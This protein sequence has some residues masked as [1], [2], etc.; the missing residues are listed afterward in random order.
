MQWIEESR[1]EI[2]K[3]EKRSF[4]SRAYRT[5]RSVCVQWTS[6][7]GSFPLPLFSFHML[8]A[9]SFNFSDS[10]SIHMVLPIKKRKTSFVPSLLSLAKEPKKLLLQKFPLSILQETKRNNQYKL[11]AEGQP[12][13]PSWYDGFSERNCKEI[14]E[15]HLVKRKVIVEPRMHLFRANSWYFL[16]RRFSWFSAAGEACRQS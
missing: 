14:W 13:K 9:A 1:M 2:I 12:E 7:T 10:V 5:V 11:A 6:A 4:Y 16:T 15:K 8:N 3:R